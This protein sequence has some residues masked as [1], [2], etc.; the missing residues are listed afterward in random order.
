MQGAAGPDKSLCSF[1]IS[2]LGGRGL[3]RDG[4]IATLPAVGVVAD[5]L[6]VGENCQGG[7]AGI[8]G[9]PDRAA[10]DDMISPVG[11]SL[12]GA[13]DAFLVTGFG[14]D[15]T[16]TG[17]DDQL[18]VG[19]RQGPDQRSFLR[20]GDDA[21]GTG[22]QCARSAFQRDVAQVAGFDQVG[23][24][25]NAVQRGQ[26][27][28]G[29]DFHRAL[30]LCGGPDN[31]RVAVDGQEIKLVL[32]Q[33]FD[34]RL[35]RCADVEQF[36]VQKDAFAVFLFQF[37]CQ[38][39]TAAGQHAKADL[40]KADGIAKTRGQVQTLHKVRDI[41][42]D[43]K[44]VIGY[45]GGL[46]WLWRLL[47]ARDGAVK[48]GRSEQ[49]ASPPPPGYFGTENGGGMILVFDIGGSRIK[50][51]RGGVGLGEA[52]TPLVDFARFVA[53]LRGFLAGGERGVAIS[54]AG[55]VQDDGRIKVANI[56]CI[57]GRI[58]AVELQ[59]A[60]GLPVLV[61]NDADCF[62]LAEVAAGAGRGHR[63]VFAVI[64]GSGVGGGLVIDGRVVPGAGEWGH[65]PVIRDPAF[66]CGCGQTGCLDT[67]GS[68]RGLERL[69][70]SLAGRELGSV[71]ILARWTGGEPMAAV[72][73]WLELVS[74]QLAMV[75][76][77]LGCTV[78]PVG[79]GLAN[80]PPLIAALDVAVRTRI[81][82]RMAGP[83]VV[84]AQVSADA[85]L[86]GAAA[87]GEAEFA[88]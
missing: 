36:H 38:R 45:H 60:L 41:K 57:D 31:L 21:I 43:D 33:A 26:Y 42:S 70:L 25:I 58:L 23:I 69:H 75:V 3:F 40:V 81:L 2:C 6:Q 46:H 72:D 13:R 19:L 68:A 71:E 8:G 74:G 4:F 35:D 86:I 84:P 66:A 20:R 11:N 32:R 14:A 67:V 82:R 56:P 9:L 28:D 53:A 52:A 5:L 16:D 87:A 39:Q 10:D 24:Q 59:A 63:N 83:L 77:V 17:G 44:A 79:G 29:Q 1:R 64:L 51:A 15:G 18:A 80:V 34:R 27:S 49:G 50:A 30:G 73:L 78:V 12:I 54:I 22:L 62:A 37:V 88:A 61:L 7:D 55:V 48:S 65:G 47:R 85:G 76:N